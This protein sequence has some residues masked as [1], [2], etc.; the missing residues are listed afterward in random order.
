MNKRYKRVE[1]P[2]W[3]HSSDESWNSGLFFYSD[4]TGSL[5]FVDR[6]E[7]SLVIYLA[8]TILSSSRGSNAPVKITTINSVFRSFLG[9]KQIPFSSLTIQRENYFAESG[10]RS[11]LRFRFYFTETLN[12]GGV[13]RRFKK[14][15]GPEKSEMLHF[16]LRFFLF[17]FCARTVWQNLVCSRVRF[18]CEHQRDTVWHIGLSNAFRFYHS[19]PSQLSLSSSIYTVQN[20]LFWSSRDSVSFYSHL[21][22]TYDV[23]LILYHLDRLL[24]RMKQ[25]AIMQLWVQCA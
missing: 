7:A 18:A 2:R 5:F 25:D 1:L 11:L 14:I 13:S 20:G 15:I 4:L 8:Y 17:S 3:Q 6:K 23:H 22:R 10:N 24:S 12:Q 21:S 9:M 16:F 19:S